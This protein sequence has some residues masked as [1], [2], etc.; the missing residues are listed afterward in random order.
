MLHIYNSVL[1]LTPFLDIRA[2]EKYKSMKGNF[3][4]QLYAAL[5]TY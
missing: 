4:M 5:A 2:I 1:D 3:I